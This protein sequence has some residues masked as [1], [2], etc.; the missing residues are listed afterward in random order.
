MREASTGWRR[1]HG[2]AAGRRRSPADVSPREMI[3]VVRHRL[4]G[5]IAILGIFAKHFRQIVSS[6]TRPAGDEPRGRTCGAR[7]WSK[8]SSMVEVRNGGRPVRSS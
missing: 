7:A 5:G 1:V 4:G 8:V 6:F 3:Q 2:A